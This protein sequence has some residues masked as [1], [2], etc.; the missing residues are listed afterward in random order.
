MSASANPSF[1]DAMLRTLTDDEVFN[2]VFLLSSDISNAL[3]GARV[4][5]TAAQR[6]NRLLVTHSWLVDDCAAS[7][8]LDHVRYTLRNAQLINAS[9]ATWACPLFNKYAPVTTKLSSGPAAAISTAPMEDVMSS[10]LLASETDALAGPV[11]SEAGPS[12]GAALGLGNLDF[13]SK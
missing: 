8:I 1:D 12:T 9:W 10:R 4:H 3:L 13:D 11:A 5:T 7:A 6:F 2:L